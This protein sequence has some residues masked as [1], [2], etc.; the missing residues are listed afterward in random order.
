MELSKFGRR[1]FNSHLK[2]ISFAETAATAFLT[3]TCIALAPEIITSFVMCTGIK[4]CSKI[5]FSELAKR[6]LISESTCS[7]LE[8]LGNQFCSFYVENLFSSKLAN[9][10][11]PR[12]TLKTLGMLTGIAHLSLMNKFFYNTSGNIGLSLSLT[13]LE[14]IFKN[15]SPSKWTDLPFAILGGSLKNILKNALTTQDESFGLNLIKSFSK[16][17]VF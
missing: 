1:H 11:L 13:S 2:K 17:T 15:N 7:W 3:S 10:L 6:N 14:E 12:Y 5:A 9:E 16:R 8:P 4:I